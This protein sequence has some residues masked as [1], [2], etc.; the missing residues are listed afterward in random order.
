MCTIY[1]TKR[2]FRDAMRNPR[3]AERAHAICRRLLG[4]PACWDGRD[5]RYPALPY[6]SKY[7]KCNTLSLWYGAHYWA[8]CAATN[9]RESVR[10]ALRWNRRCFAREISGGDGPQPERLHGRWRRLWRLAVR[11]VWALRA[12]ALVLDTSVRW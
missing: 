11:R 5:I 12:E 1:F 6:Y 2:D 3:T 9:L 10:D 7:P 4:I 8:A